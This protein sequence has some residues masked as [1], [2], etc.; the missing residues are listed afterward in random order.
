MRITFVGIVFF[1]LTSA[2]AQS[3]AP[4]VPA[5][6]WSNN[7]SIYEVNIR[8]YT[9][10]GTFSAFEKHLPRLKEMGVGILWLMP[11]NPIGEKNRKG[12]LGSYYSIEDY[13][14]VNPEFGTI[15]DL[16]HLVKTAHDMGM[17]VIIDWVANHTA[18]D[19]VWMKDHKDYYT[20][21]NGKIIP[22]V[23]DWSDVADL[24]YDNPQLRK[25]ML[26]A[27]KYWLNE[28]HI[29][30]F[31]CD[32]AMMV[33]DDFW[34]NTIA[35]L[36]KI[37]PDLFMLAEAEGPQFHYD[38]FNMTYA[39]NMHHIMNGVAQGKRDVSSIDSL[40][41][42]EEKEYPSCSYRMEFTSNHDENS[43]NGS[44]F[45]RMGKSAP[46]FAVLCG[47][48]PGMLLIYSG[49]EA[50]MNKRLKFF[51]KDTIMWTENSSYAG[52]YKTLNEL[53]KTNPALRNDEEGKYQTLYCGN[54]TLAFMRAWGEHKVIAIFNFG[55][56]EQTIT[57]ND[58][59]LKG[60]YTNVFEGSKKKLKTENKFVLS[61]L[62]YLVLSK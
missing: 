9:P 24:N 39:W 3:S 55:N 62:E 40:I 4:C 29:D 42:A 2:S 50:G 17:Y 8:Q 18:W 26:N 30:G 59:S 48:M 58:K 57:I 1:I 15:D 34:K 54:N 33:P 19:N 32:V 22:P 5:P 31:R 14:A 27:M 28:V 51:D 36:K 61:P 13:T 53:K 16:K 38:G 44:E 43:W 25:A 60:K 10:E 46:T 21:E 49:Q 35:E 47:T 52:I 7:L 56:T 37:N 41:H 6:S 12:S 11:V 23:A 45:E 20:S